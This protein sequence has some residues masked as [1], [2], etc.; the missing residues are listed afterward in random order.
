MPW[1]EVGCAAGV[2]Q[3]QVIE[4]L[5]DLGVR[6]VNACNHLQMSLTDSP[7]YILPVEMI[8]SLQAGGKIHPFCS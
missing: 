2:Q 8:I 3:Q 6:L 5:R 1:P 7:F 4:A